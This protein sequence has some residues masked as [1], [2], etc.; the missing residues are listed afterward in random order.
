MGQLCSVCPLDTL[1]AADSFIL[2]SYFKWKTKAQNINQNIFCHILWGLNVL[3]FQTTNII[4]FKYRKQTYLIHIPIGK[5][6]GGCR[7][8]SKNNILVNDRFSFPRA[9]SYLKRYLPTNSWCQ[10]RN[11]T[12]WTCLR[13]YNVFWGH[14]KAE[15]SWCDLKHQSPCCSP[16]FIYFFGISPW[17]E[18]CNS[19]WADVIYV[20]RWWSCKNK[21]PLL[22]VD[23][24]FFIYILHLY[25]QPTST[26]E[27]WERRP[28]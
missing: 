28:S 19:C 25:T 23:L 20:T 1:H 5:H 9:I 7:I 4:F 22:T 17:N 11:L 2:T 6:L 24:W 15:M 13:Q 3:Y 10:I 18:L 8:P 27:K 12:A 21:R 16:L 26:A 14:C